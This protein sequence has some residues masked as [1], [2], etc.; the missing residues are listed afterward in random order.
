MDFAATVVILLLV[1][2]P[3]GNAPV[4]HPIL[5]RVAPERRR[6]V[7][8]RELIIAY[9][10]LLF[11][12]VAGDV[13]LGFLGIRGETLS[14]SGGIL[15]FLI[16]LGMIFPTKSVLLEPGDDEPFIVPLAVPMIAGPSAIAMLLLLSSKNP[17]S[18]WPGVAAVTLAWAASAGILLL[19]PV[20]L[21]RIGRKGT[22]AMERLMGLVLIL[23]AVQMFIDG[24]GVIMQSNGP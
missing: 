2:D 3:I 7:L 17:G 22:Q 9:L 13:I 19:A 6:R 8:V 18:L 23:I 14:I 15:L 12:L 21:N 24:L 16:A 1:L 5:Q 10:I 20:I 4:F 11:F